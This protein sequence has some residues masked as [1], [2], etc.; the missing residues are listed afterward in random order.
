[1][2][3][4]FDEIPSIIDKRIIQKLEELGLS[5]KESRVYIALLP[6]GSVGT[7]SLIRSTGLHGQFVYL[8]LDRLEELGLV[9]HVIQT[10][11][12]KFSANSPTRL[13]SLIEEKRIAAQTVIK[14]LQSLFSPSP[15]QDFE[16]YQGSST[17]VAHEFEMLHAM[18]DGAEI[19]VI[20]GGGDKYMELMGHK[21]DEY[22]RIRL[23]K[24]IQ[25]R[26]ISTGGT[27]LYLQ[28]MVQT[29]KL[30]DYRVL[31]TPAQGV[32]MDIFPDRTVFDFL[33]ESAVKFSFTNK[34]ISNGYKQF[35]NVL[36][37][38]TSK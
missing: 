17:Y 8:A 31:T 34:V 9:K 12:K 6:L 4:K 10:G 20:G 21:I 16:I 13:L 24:K 11:R 7:S 32:A 29:R 37:D 23:I 2:S 22:E 33:D 18:P 14:E 5:D 28:V 15:K 35:F 27:P 3:K 38:L 36:W 26:Y 19:C 1:M 30:F 25:I